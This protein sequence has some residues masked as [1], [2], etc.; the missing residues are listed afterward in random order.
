MCALSSC[1]AARAVRPFGLLRVNVLRLTVAS[2][3][4]W[5]TGQRRA[6]AHTQHAWPEPALNFGPALPGDSL[7][8]GANRPGYPD[9]TVTGGTV[10]RWLQAMQ[11]T[12]GITRVL[13]LLGQPQLQIYEPEPRVLTTACLAEGTCQ[14][15]LLRRYGAAFG[16]ERVHWLP[17][18]D[19]DIIP[20]EQVRP[21]ANRPFACTSALVLSGLPSRNTM[22]FF[23]PRT[24][25]L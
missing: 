17:A 3:H 24:V 5:G 10:D 16:A 25:S 19:F 8:F 18:I 13:C 23:T 20:P 2:T 6:H 14:P 12:H 22:H 15:E 21:T 11:E 9:K 7:V 4:I 1:A